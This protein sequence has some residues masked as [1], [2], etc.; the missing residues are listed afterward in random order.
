LE[1]R[2]EDRVG[3]CHEHVESFQG[4]AVVVVWQGEPA[5]KE[6]ALGAVGLDFE[7]E[8]EELRRLQEIHVRTYSK[9]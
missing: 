6:R 3:A 2:H 7:W 8:P 5:M 4:V 1:R 9:A